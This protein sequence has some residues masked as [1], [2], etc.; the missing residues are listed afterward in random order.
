[1][2]SV[3]TEEVA[4]IVVFEKGSRTGNYVGPLTAVPGIIIL[5]IGGVTAFRAEGGSGRLVGY[6][7]IAGG[8]AIA[9]A[10]WLLG[11]IIGDALVPENRT[12][13][14]LIYEGPV[15]RYLQDDMPP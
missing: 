9:A 3:P 2:Q 11:S 1:M 13:E 14:I 15:E 5:G 12:Q 8:I 6:V 10:G 7:L 4:R